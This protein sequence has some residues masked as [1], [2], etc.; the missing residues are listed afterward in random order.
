MI[1]A[2]PEL[3][4]AQSQMHTQQAQ[5]IPFNQM[6]VVNAFPAIAAWQGTDTQIGA[7]EKGEDTTGV[8]NGTWSSDVLLV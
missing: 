2:L 8:E 3:Y 1:K 6:E 7:S 4:Q 5:D